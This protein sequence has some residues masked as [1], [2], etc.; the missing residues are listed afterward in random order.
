MIN[1]RE[2]QAISRPTPIDAVPAAGRFDGIV[3]MVGALEVGRLLAE[4]RVAL[5]HPYEVVIYPEEEGTGFDAVLTGSKAWVGELSPQ[6]LA[7]MHDCAGTSYLAAMETYGLRA[8]NLE[9]QHFRPER[10]KAI[11]DRRASR[12]G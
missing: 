6:Q 3:G 4:Q 5:S 12:L 9:R 1:V 7:P 8:A 2:N 11:L 10:A